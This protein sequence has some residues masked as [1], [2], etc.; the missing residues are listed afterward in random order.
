MVVEER[1]CWN[2]SF[3]CQVLQIAQFFWTHVPVPSQSGLLTTY[4]TCHPDLASWLITCGS[5]L[6]T[7]LRDD[8][9]LGLMPVLRKL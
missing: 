1:G 9:L 7:R 5:W 2:R 4:F 8:K 3:S 6:Y